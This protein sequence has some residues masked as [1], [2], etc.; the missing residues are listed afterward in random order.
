[1]FLLRSG[2]N[3]FSSPF[4]TFFL[5]FSSLL[6]GPCVVVSFPFILVFFTSGW[7]RKTKRR[8]EKKKNTETTAVVLT[9]ALY[10][11][12]LYTF[13]LSPLIHFF[14]FI[15]N[16][17]RSTICPSLLP[18]CC[19]SCLH[20]FLHTASTSALPR[21]VPAPPCPAPSPPLTSPL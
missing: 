5:P 19:P 2:D 11:V 9:F 3:M 20:L 18:S 1:M 10:C 8:K 4:P 7:K 14:S 16:L 12:A 6:P 21:L 13:L 17:L 15:Q